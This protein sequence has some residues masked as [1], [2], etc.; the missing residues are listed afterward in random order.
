MP[1]RKEWMNCGKGLKSSPIQRSGKQGTKSKPRRHS[2]PS[3]VPSEVK[4]LLRRR[5]GGLCEVGVKCS[6]RAPG[7]D[8]AHREGKKSGGTS[9]PWSNLASNLLWS[10]RAC[11]DEIDNGS[12]ASAERSGLKIREGVARP[13]EIPVRHAARGW[14]LLDDAGGSRPAP[15][16]S[17][18]AVL[19]PVVAVSAWDLMLQSGAFLEAMQRYKHL[20]CPGWAPPREGG[21][22]CGCGSTPFLL[23]VA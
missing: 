12:P 10:C 17:H 23:E 7:V 4:D 16:A 15:E 5:S 8:P 2:R 6:G 13:W 14:V 18:G 1:R 9:K 21:F 3:T 22:T 11:H 20:D 19:L